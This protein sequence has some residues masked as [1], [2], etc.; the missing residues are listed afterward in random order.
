MPFVI[1]TQVIF[2]NQMLYPGEISFYNKGR[3]NNRINKQINNFVYLDTSGKSNV[4]QINKHVCVCCDVICILILSDVCRG[5]KFN[6]NIFLI[7]LNKL[8]CS[9][10]LSV[11]GVIYWNI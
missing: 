9:I 4:T 7:K 2:I 6:R 10:L 5:Y 11:G 8:L 1:F 3:T